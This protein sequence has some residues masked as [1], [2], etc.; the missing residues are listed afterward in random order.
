MYWNCV[1]ATGFGSASAQ[2]T[3]TECVRYLQTWLPEMNNGYTTILDYMQIYFFLI[4]HI[5]QN[6]THIFF[7]LISLPDKAICVVY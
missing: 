5:L 3:L 4:F 6:S 2:L 7:F 1:K